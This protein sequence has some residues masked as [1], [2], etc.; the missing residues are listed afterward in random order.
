MID[1]DDTLP[2]VRAYAPGRTELAGNHTDHQGGRVIA[3]TLDCGIEMIVQASGSQ[4]ARVESECFP[5]VEIDISDSAPHAGERGSTVALVRGVV[6]GLRK[7]GLPVGGFNARVKSSVPPGSGLSSSAAF[8]LALAC[9]LELLFQGKRF[10]SADA[11]NADG[12]TFRRL[13]PVQLARI[14]QAAERDWFGKPCGLMDQLS[15][16]L[17]GIHVM[18]FSNNRV[19]FERIRFDFEQA[20]LALLLVDTQCDHSRYTSEY[21]R[22][23]RDMSD[24]ARHMGAQ[25][26]SQ[27]PEETFLQQFKKLRRE[28]GDLPALRALHYY[29]EMSLVDIR[30]KALREGDVDAFLEATRRSGASSAQYLQNV[31]VTGTVDQPAMVALAAADHA[32]GACGAARIHGGG[33]GGSI[34]AFVPLGQASTFT[35]AMN[36]LLGRGSC[37]RFRITETGACATWLA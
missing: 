14:A 16:A 26:L 6:A 37:R 1:F 30:A 29:H 22:V 33:F 3:A 11:A 35:D 31:S 36:A 27:I 19:Q 24:A 20:G 2:C 23:A 21:A 9:G 15:V 12:A 10:D 25:T 18:D 17:G 32:A 8:E 7:E 4:C 13:S 34:Q 28:L 5:P